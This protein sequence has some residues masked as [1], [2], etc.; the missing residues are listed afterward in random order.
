MLCSFGGDAL[1]VNS[2]CNIGYGCNSYLGDYYEL[3]SANENYALAGTSW[4]K[5]LEMEV[6]KVL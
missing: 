3:P 6:Y 1:N 5:I 4:F 2:N